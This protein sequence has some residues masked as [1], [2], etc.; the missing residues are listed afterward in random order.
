MNLFFM[1]GIQI[2]LVLGS[3]SKLICFFVG[4]SKSTSVLCAG[5][6]YLVLVY[7]SKL[8]VRAENYLFLVWGSIDV[9]FVRVVEIDL[10]FVCWPKITWLQGFS[11]SI[12]LDFV[13]VWVVEIDLISVGGSNLT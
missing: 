12:E 5:R 4:G 7:G 1:G 13:F 3:G 10:V 11:V 2:D 6:I 9:I 8:C